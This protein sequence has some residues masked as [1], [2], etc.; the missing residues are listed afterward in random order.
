M[1]YTPVGCDN[2][3]MTGYRGRL[4]VTEIVVTDSDLERGIAAGAPVDVLTAIARRSGCRSLWESSVEHLK[5]GETSGDELLRV[6]DQH[7]P[8]EP[9]PDTRVAVQH[10]FDS[11]D[12]SQNP[13]EAEMTEVVAGVVDIYVIRPL[14]EGWK[15][16]VVQRASNTRCPGAWETI[17]GRLNKSER[18][19]DG[20]VRE[21]RE[22]T[23]LN[24]ARLYNVTVQPFYLHMFGTVQLAV[25]FAAFVDEPAEVTLSEEHQKH[26]WLSPHEASS[27]FIW[28]REREALSHI[29]HLLAGGNAGPVEDVLRVI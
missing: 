8:L 2:C 17:H 6:L 24:I 23:A 15:V 7:V 26:E 1:V 20:A 18:P 29:L 9:A 16:L 3:S 10:E 4:A 13:V 21:V 19:E 28:P 11:E 27:R 22:E 25:V 5:A 12:D 14:A